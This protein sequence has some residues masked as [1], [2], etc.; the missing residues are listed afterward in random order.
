MRLSL[1]PPPL[2]RPRRWPARRLR[3]PEP[4]TL[5]SATAALPLPLP[6]PTE[7]AL[8]L[9][10]RSRGGEDRAGEES[11]EHE[12]GGRPARARLGL[13]RFQLTISPIDLIGSSTRLQ[14][15]PPALEPDHRQSPHR[16]WP[17]VLGRRC[18]DKAAPKMD[19]WKNSVPPDQ[20]IGWVREGD[21]FFFRCPQLPL[22]KISLWP[23]PFNCL[24]TLCQG[25]FAR[26][27]VRV[28]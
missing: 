25:G 1:S 26:H 10:S 7:P 3:A 19:Y 13:V 5:H 12:V 23:G 6:P 8:V 17:L 24:D 11:L 21:I 16:R 14:L 18:R 15:R 20:T 2:A 9:V 27:D 4:R 22:P 28:C